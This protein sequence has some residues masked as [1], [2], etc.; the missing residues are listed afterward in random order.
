MTGDVAPSRLAPLSALP[1]ARSQGVTRGADLDITREA[2]E[3]VPPALLHGAREALQRIGQN[4][5]GAYGVTSTVRGEGRS[6]IATALA[7]VEWLDFERRVVLVDLDL[8]QPSLHERLGLREG[9]GIGDLVQGHNSVEDYVQRIVGDVWLLSAGRSRDDAP[10]GL[11]RLAESTILSQLSEWA[12][13]AVF[14]LPP[15][16]ESTTGAD[17]ARLCGTPIM[18]VRAGVVPLPQVKE[19]VSKLASPPPVILNGVRSKVPT[20]IRRSLGDTR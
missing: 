17:A 9:P 16:L 7:L 19:A 1:A 18:V 15:L 20:W 12:D 11:N 10:R 13:V 4:G 8:E 6:S 5:H 2:R 14:D 3:L